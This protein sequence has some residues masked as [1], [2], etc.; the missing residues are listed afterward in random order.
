MIQ[1]QSFSDCAVLFFK[2]KYKVFRLQC[3]S[4]LQACMRVSHMRHVVARLV[5]VLSVSMLAHIVTHQ[6]SIG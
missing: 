2:S 1:M 6:S 5:C 4:V 3:R